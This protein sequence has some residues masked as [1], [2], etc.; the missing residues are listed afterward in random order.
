[1]KRLSILPTLTCWWATTSLWTGK[2]TQN[3]PFRLLERAPDTW[4]IRISPGK[5]CW[6]TWASIKQQLIYVIM[7]VRTPKP[8]LPPEEVTPWSRTSLAEGLYMEACRNLEE[9]TLLPTFYEDQRLARPWCVSHS[10]QYK[11]NS[12]EKCRHSVLLARKA[13]PPL[14]QHSN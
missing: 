7:S 2:E 13:H 14:W 1:M 6:S 3:F 8:D 5:S 11:L 9:D 10:T 12:A 4:G